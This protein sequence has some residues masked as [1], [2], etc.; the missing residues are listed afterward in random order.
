MHL[1]CKYGRW[2]YVDDGLCEQYYRDGR[3]T[4]IYEGTTYIQALDLIGRKIAKDG[5]AVN[6]ND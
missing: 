1:S 3:I 2:G 5:G 6:E 4:M